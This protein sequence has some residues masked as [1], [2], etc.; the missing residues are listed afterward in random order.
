MT[1]KPCRGESL[2]C[3]I[4]LNIM[5][6]DWDRCVEMGARTG[7]KFGMRRL[8]AWV[9]TPDTPG[10]TCL[11]LETRAFFPREVE[12]I[13]LVGPGVGYLVSRQMMVVEI[14]EEL[15]S[16]RM[17]YAM[18]AAGLEEVWEMASRRS[19]TR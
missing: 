12:M 10:S 18:L 13:Q 11:G 2:L 15:E 3:N 5:V 16:R 7:S 14:W 4:I 19:Q 6:K 9:A 17:V 1:R 8:G